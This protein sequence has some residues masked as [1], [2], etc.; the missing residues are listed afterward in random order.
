MTVSLLAE[1][2]NIET[3]LCAYFMKKIILRR[4]TNA[5]CWRKMFSVDYWIG[6]SNN[7]TKTSCQPYLSAVTKR[8]FRLGVINNLV[9]LVW[10]CGDVSQKTTC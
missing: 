2:G 1:N 9:V 3:S 10:R 4:N 6:G 5:C 7:Q 8:F